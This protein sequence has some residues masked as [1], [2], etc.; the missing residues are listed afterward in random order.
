MELLLVTNRA[1]GRLLLT[2][3]VITFGLAGGLWWFATRLSQ[4][5]RRLSGAVSVAMEEGIGNGMLPLTADRDELG[6]LARNNERLLRA[7]ADY[8]QYLQTLAGKLSHE[9]KTPLA[10]TRSSLEN[11]ASRPLDADSRQFVERAQEGLE[12][13]AA[14]VRAMSEASRLEAAIRV[15]EWEAADLAALLRQCAAG[16]RDVH[17]GRKIDV[18]AP[19]GP[20]V[21]RCAPELQAQALDKLVDNAVT[22][23]GPS[24]R[25]VLALAAAGGECRIAVRNTGSPRGAAGPAVRLAGVAAGEA[26]RDAAPRPRPLHR[27]A[28]RGRSRRP[29]VST[30]PARRRRGRVRAALPGGSRELKAAR[31]AA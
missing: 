30:Q 26:R 5:V 31:R 1:L 22:L 3:L 29:G 24:D 10:I 28:G 17:A 12:R 25:V 14:I 27:P 16:Y 4:R 9:L 23:S 7:V 6:E 11:L 20:V 18:E 19:D 13:Q 8:N 15:A 21:V 2:T